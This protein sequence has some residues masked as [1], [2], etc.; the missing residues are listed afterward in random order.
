MG[1]AERSAVKRKAFL[2]LRERYRRRGAVLVYVDESGFARSVTR[3][4]GRA[5]R[6]QKVYGVCCGRSR[7]RTSLLA[8]RIEGQGFDCPVLF[9]GTCT[10]AVF[11]RWL[12]TWLVPRLTAHHVVILDNAAFHQSA[13]TR[14]LIEQTG[15]RLLFLPS[16]SP[17]LNPI[18]H[19]FANLKKRREYH[20]HLS[21]DDL[22]KSYCYLCE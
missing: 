1:Y 16:Y 9:E 10:A 8:A 15:A 2:R 14:I 3:R 4:H 19:D 6:G 18:E 12:E 11:N 20:P 13:T 21:L 7:P 17:D 5:L 22:V